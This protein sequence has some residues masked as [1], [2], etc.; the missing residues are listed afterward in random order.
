MEISGWALNAEHTV[1]YGC[2]QCTRSLRGAL[3]P[4]VCMVRGVID[5]RLLFSLESWLLQCQRRKLY[6]TSTPSA[7]VFRCK[8]T[9]PQ[10]Q[11]V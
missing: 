9:L 5:G 6:I 11:P 1:M 2:I 3:H 8:M 10:G 7:F 4:E